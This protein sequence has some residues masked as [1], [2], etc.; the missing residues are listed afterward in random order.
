MIFSYLVFLLQPREKLKSPFTTLQP[1][2]CLICC[3]NPVSPIRPPKRVAWT[4]STS[5]GTLPTTTDCG[6]RLCSWPHNRA[7]TSLWHRATI[8]VKSIC[9]LMHQKRI[10]RKLYPSVIGSHTTVG[11]SKYLFS[12]QIFAEMTLFSFLCI[13]QS[14]LSLFFSSVIERDGSKQANSV[15]QTLTQRSDLTILYLLSDSREE[16]FKKSRVSRLD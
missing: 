7:F 5:H 15:N 13:A 12:S 4:I 3:R 9:H 2:T 6:S 11:I 16:S 1:K 14:N 8:S 10:S